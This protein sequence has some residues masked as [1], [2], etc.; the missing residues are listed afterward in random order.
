[1]TNSWR[2]RD[3]RSQT[4]RKRMTW[5]DSTLIK[6]LES[7][8]VVVINVLSLETLRSTCVN[9]IGQKRFTGVFFITD[10]AKTR[11][12]EGKVSVL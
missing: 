8:F 1:M 10:K 6:F 3:E 5:F 12:G 2:W 11:R 9:T 7:S 4:R